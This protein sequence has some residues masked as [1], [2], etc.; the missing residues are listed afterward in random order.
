MPSFLIVHSAPR[1]GRLDAYRQPPTLDVAGLRA[2]LDWG[3]ITLHVPAGDLPVTVYVTRA[4]GEIEG[5][6]ITVRSPAGT[7][8]RLTFV[9]PLEAGGR[10]LLRIDGQ[11]PSD[12]SMHYYAARDARTLQPPSGASAP[13]V[14]F[15]ASAPA[16]Q[17]P[18][19]SPTPAVGPMPGSTGSVPSQPSDF[20]REQGARVDPVRSSSP[21]APAPQRDQQPPSPGPASQ[22]PHVGPRPDAQQSPSFGQRPQRVER[23]VYGREH[24]ADDKQAPPIPT[25]AEFHRLE[26][27]AA[28]AQRRVYEAWQAQQHAQQ[29]PQVSSGHDGAPQ[30]IGLS[31][32]T[33]QAPP[34]WYP[35]PF[36]RA[37]SRWF[38]GRQWSASVMRGG[39]RETDQ[40][41]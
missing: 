2:P 23:D 25:P 40:P 27:E 7:G 35:D 31:A 20:G 6:T 19:T 36:R 15:A 10:S 37:D 34:D 38:D 9:P 1:D 29:P 21:Q 5:A 18:P 3:D 33:G 13:A 39:R 12:S 14:S 24:A 30:P 41:G 16:R 17:V 32:S 11:W 26:R 28:D 4:S 8:T 22:P